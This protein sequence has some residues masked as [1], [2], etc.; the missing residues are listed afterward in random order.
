MDRPLKIGLISPYD[1]AV[2]GGVND[3]INSLASQFSRWGHDVRVIAPCS[4]PDPEVEGFIPMGRPVP[5]PSG[6]SIARISLSVWLRPRIKALLQR[7]AFD[8]IHLHEPFAGAV[9][10]NVLSVATSVPS[11]TVGTFHS[12]R[13]T[14]LYRVG[15]RQFAMR[16]FRRLH[17]RIA[18]SEPARNFISR[19]FPAD[20]EIIPNGIQVDDFADAKP[21]PHLNDG[22]TN[23]L[24]VGRL[25][26]RKGLRYL[27][28]AYSKLK[29]DWPDLRLLVAGRGKPDD[30][31]YR[32]IAERNLQDVVFL[33]DVSAQNKARYYKSADIYCS[34]ATGRES[35]G[36]VLLEA[37]AAGTAVVASDIEGYSSVLNHGSDGLLVRPKDEAQLSA[38]LDLLL[39]QP[40]YRNRLAAAAR[41][42][43]ERFRWEEVAGEVMDHYGSLLE[44]PA[45]VSL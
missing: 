10:V 27:L 9:P 3:H 2:H 14:R 25:E 1:Y 12:F 43:V 28:G 19:H 38:A 37:M 17:G 40:E 18:G 21:F 26:K 8:V 13:G 6:G 15:I 42:K 16:Y 31:S 32:I 23:I 35:F 41:K 22:K 4:T 24:F 20:Y 36:I 33:G 5:V 39:T 11:I 34:P 7:E 44:R 30:E 29:W 45:A